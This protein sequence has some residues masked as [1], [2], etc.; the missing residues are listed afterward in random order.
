MHQLLRGKCICGRGQVGQ[1]G[2]NTRALA[3]QGVSAMLMSSALGHNNTTTLS[4]YLSL[5]YMQGSSEANRIIAGL[6]NE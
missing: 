1:G 3:E 5:S 6:T 2:G 4:K